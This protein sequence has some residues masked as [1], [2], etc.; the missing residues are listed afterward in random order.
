M[1]KVR[2]VIQIWILLKWSS[3]WSRWFLLSEERSFSMNTMPTERG[4]KEGGL[5]VEDFSPSIFQNSCLIVFMSCLGSSSGREKLRKGWESGPKDK[6][7]QLES[8]SCWTLYSLSISIFNLLFPFIVANQAPSV[9][10]KWG[11]N[12][13]KPRAIN[14]ERRKEKGG[15]FP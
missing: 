12:I 3:V 1:D 4:R 15:S 2:G 14:K 8:L 10:G 13:V 9:I 6:R 11:Y 5:R 7:R